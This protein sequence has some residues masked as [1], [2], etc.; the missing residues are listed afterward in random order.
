M[1]WGSWS[2][3]LEMGGYAGYVWGSFGM[4]ALCIACEIVLLIKRRRRLRGDSIA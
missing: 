4:T 3:F 1:N 2:A